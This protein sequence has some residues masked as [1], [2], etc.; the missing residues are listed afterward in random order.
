MKTMKNVLMILLGAALVLSLA[1]VGG[2]AEPITE[3]SDSKSGQF[4]VTYTIGESYEVTVPVDVD[5]KGQGQNTNQEVIVNAT[6]TPGKVLNISVMSA[7]GWEMRIAETNAGSGIEYTMSY[8]DDSVTFGGRN[9]VEIY[10]TPDSV[11]KDIARIS[12]STT[13]SV[14]NL[15]AGIYTDTLTFTVGYK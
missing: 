7:N 6:V 13:D 5:L 12:F 14:E 9:P 2:A 11:T 8:G 3:T 1:G 4:L 10:S 15:P